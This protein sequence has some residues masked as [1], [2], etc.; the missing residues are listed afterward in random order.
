MDHRRAREDGEDAWFD[1]GAGQLNNQ[2][3]DTALVSAGPYKICEGSAAYDLGG[4]WKT[5]TMVAGVDDSST[6]PT[7]R[8]SVTVDGSPLWS[9]DLRI[10]APKPLSLDVANGRRLEISYEDPGRACRLGPVTLGAPTL[11]K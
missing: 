1:A 11:K 6:Y 9:G 7:V 2:R 10:G 8:M 4:G 3:Y 5:L